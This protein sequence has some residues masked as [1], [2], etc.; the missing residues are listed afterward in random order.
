[1]RT[2]FAKFLTVATL[3][4]LSCALA[5]LSVFLP[6]TI[7]NRTELR[8]VNLGFPFSFI[9][10]NQGSLPVGYPDYPQFP[11]RQALLSPWEY[12]LQVIWWR[13][14]LDIAIVYIALVLIRVM[15]HILWQRLQSALAWRNSR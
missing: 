8:Q 3:L 6:V 7:H 12:M 10:Q 5:G 14:L 4:V 1:M 13:F 9:I 15:V 11:I 2:N